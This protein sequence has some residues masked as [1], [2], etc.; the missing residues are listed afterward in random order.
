MSQ[1]SRDPLLKHYE[2][3]IEISRQLNSTFD[4]A[5]LLRKIVAAATEL[6]DTEA[7]SIM[8]IDPITE[9]LRFEASSNLDP[10]EMDDIIVPMKGSIAGWI[11]THGEPRVIQDVASE[12]SHFQNVDKTIDFQTNN[13]LGVPMRTHE[14]IIGV[15]Q[16][17][18]KR[19]NQKFTSV[20]I[21]TMTTLAS[22][23][24]VAIEN[25]RLFRQSD[26]IA[27]M[28]H[29]LRTPLMSLKA[30]IALFRRQ[31]LTNDKKDDLVTT[32]QGETNRLIR[33]TTDFLDLAQ[34]ESGRTRLEIQPFEISDLLRESAE[35]VAPQASEKD[36]TIYTDDT[37]HTIKGDRGK[38]KQVLLNLITNAIKYNRAGGDIRLWTRPVANSKHPMLQVAVEDTGYGLSKD[39]QQQMFQKFFRASQT[40]D[41]TSGT[42]LG[43]VI[44]KAIIEAHDGQIWLESEEDVGTTFFFT[45][46]TLP[47]N[48]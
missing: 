8:L 18:N 33:L 40:A 27:E 30:S 26:F 5:Q 34:M 3:I 20:D 31:D 23:A 12:P 48:D 19:G 38:V 42:G 29:E 46:P 15:V 47:G 25:A 9:E 13:L 2:R 4:H 32:M 43:L 36:I 1:D 16:A 21:N 45:L 11:A 14:K 22:Q 44:T 39:D 37:Q 17:V 10:N 28:V 41:K 6:V 7:A 24:A 35:V